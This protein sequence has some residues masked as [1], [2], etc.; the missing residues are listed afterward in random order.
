MP[1]V[2]ASMFGLAA[3]GVQSAAVRLLMRGVA[4]TNLMTTNTSQIPID[5]TQ[6]A[7]ARLYRD[8]GS[9]EVADQREVR[10]RRL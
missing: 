6:Q 1:V 8:D 10:C 9:A 5:A 3:M 7:W 2:V 4:S